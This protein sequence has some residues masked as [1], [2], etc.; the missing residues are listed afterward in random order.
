LSVFHNSRG[1][2]PPQISP[3]LSRPSLS[4]VIDDEFELDSQMQNDPSASSSIT[5]SGQD[6]PIVS[7]NQPGFFGV[8]FEFNPSTQ[9]AIIN[10]E[11]Y[12][13]HSET[14]SFIPVSNP[15][16]CQHFIRWRDFLVQKSI[17]EREQAEQ[18]E[19]ERQLIQ[20]KLNRS[21]QQQQQQVPQVASFLQSRVTPPV[22]PSRVSPPQQ[23][24]QSDNCFGN[25]FNNS[26]FSSTNT[27]G[28]SQNSSNLISSFAPTVVDRF[29][30]VCGKTPASHRYP[31][32]RSCY[33]RQQKR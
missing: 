2:S 32:C 27:K 30:N 31:T 26:A 6:S 17:R 21:G 33:S 18:A 7:D 10:G 29:C 22:S 9:F 20:L 24:Q 3:L 11:E 23:Q 16:F 13:F 28:F 19:L 8:K 4:D 25:S 5:S 15:E 1:G 12:F 14:K